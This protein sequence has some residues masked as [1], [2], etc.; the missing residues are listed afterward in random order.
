MMSNSG[1]KSCPIPGFHREDVKSVGVKLKE[2]IIKMRKYVKFF[3]AYT[4][5]ILYSI[6]VVIVVNWLFKN[7]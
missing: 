4:V 2:S 7:I 3:I 6:L 1:K 5:A